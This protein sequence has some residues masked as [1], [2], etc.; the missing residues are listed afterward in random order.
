MEKLRHQPSQQI[1]AAAKA[2]SITKS[3]LVMGAFTLLT[4]CGGSDSDD[5]TYDIYATAGSGGTITPGARNVAENSTTTLTVSANSGYTIDNVSGCGGSLVGNTYTTGTINAN[6][7]IIATFSPIIPITVSAMAGTGGTIAPANQ[8]AASGASTTV[9]LTPNN[10]YAI[11]QVSGCGGTLAGNTYTTSAITANCAVIATFTPI[12]PITVTAMASTGGSLTPA[13]QTVTSG[14]NTAITV[15]ANTGYTIDQVR[16]CEGSLIGNTFTTGAITANCAVFATFLPI[17]T[18]TPITVSAVASTG[19]S[20]SPANQIVAS[21]A[22]TAITVTANSGYTIDQVSG[23]DGSL[24]G[25]TYTTSNITA[26]CTVFATFLPIVPAAPITINAIA[27]TGGSITPASQIVTSGASTSVSVTASS[28]YTIDQVSGCG[29]SLSGNTYTTDP[30]N[31]SC[32]IFATFSPVAPITVSAAASTGGSITPASQTVANG[33]ITSV[34]VTA[35]SGYTIDQVSGCDG[36]LSGN[37]YT[38]GTISESC[39][40]FATFTP[41]APITVSATAGTG[42]SITPTTQTIASG[43]TTSVTVTANSDYDIDQVTGCDGNLVGNTYTTGAITAN[44]VIIATFSPITVTTTANTGGSIT[45]ASQTVASGATTSVTVTADNGYSINQVTGCGGSLAG[46]V[47]TTGI[48]TSSCLVSATFTPKITVNTSA[49]TGGTIVPN[50]R[51]ID[52]GS[53]TQFTIAANS[54]YLLNNVSGCGGNLIGSTYTT[55]NVLA[56]CTVSATFT[57][58]RI[59]SASAGSGGSISP[60]SRTVANGSTTTFTVSPNSGYTLDSISGCDGTLSGDT[61]TTDTLAAN[62]SITANFRPKLSLFT[63]GFHTCAV[64][65]F[66]DAKCWGQNSSGQ[67]GVASF[68]LTAHGDEAG[69]A[70]VDNDSVTLPDLSLSYESLELGGQHSCAIL[71]DQNLYCWGES[72]NGQLGLGINAD[73]KIMSSNSVDLDGNA[74]LEVSAGGQFTCARLANGELYCWGLNS[75]GELGIGDA[76]TRFVPAGPVALDDL[77]AQIAAGG[78]HACARLID[79]SVQCWGDNS[80]GQLGDNDGGNDSAT[81]SNV[82][83]GGATEVTDIASGGLFSCVIVDGDVKCWGE[84]GSGQLGNNDG[85]NTDLDVVSAALD[86]DGETPVKLALGSEHACVLTESGSVYCWGESDAGQTG[87][88]DTTD[89]IAPA[90]VDLGAYT[91]TGIAA[92][93]DHVCVNL[94]PDDNLDLTRPI[95]CWGESGVGQLGLEDTSDIGDNEVINNILFNIFPWP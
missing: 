59:A 38:T 54:G 65:D 68:S 3:L 9:T 93:G 2:F 61:Y 10:G 64:N 77:P 22:T 67:L 28:G 25:N 73:I 24:M 27:G 75:S 71:S 79:N 26:N 84:N 66:T 16:G 70:P 14:A 1:N 35:D 88:N 47:Y 17:A 39:V 8:N 58:A 62:C 11:D 74:V 36:N 60:A 45:P 5:T 95:R 90:L 19:G 6:C 21:G 50:I 52:Y 57:T 94:L 81:P 63:G 44:C 51:S 53:N 12:T 69:E 87:Q 7:A 89:D 91:A 20:I 48:I 86:I 49:G 92:G 30:L 31:T 4:A 72:Q 32:V 80:S 33:A 43:A 13:S 56:N 41:I 23:C 42:G 83:L 29:G 18:T 78:S 40:I 15:T 34:T 76:N 46:N 85:T 37:T 82:N 55:S